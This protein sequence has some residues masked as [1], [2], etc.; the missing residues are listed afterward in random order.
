[1]MNQETFE[2]IGRVLLLFGLSVAILAI[3][4]LCLKLFIGL[5]P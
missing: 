3:A 5:Y 1:M 4:G 2:K